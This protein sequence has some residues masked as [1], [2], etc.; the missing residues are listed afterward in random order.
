MDTLGVGTRRAMPAQ[1][2][3]VSHTQ[4]ASFSKQPCWVAQGHNELT[5][6]SELMPRLITMRAA[7]H[8]AEPILEHTGLGMAPQAS[9]HSR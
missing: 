9:R 5:R 8:D 4:P 7:A 1:V 3:G 2:A 6:C